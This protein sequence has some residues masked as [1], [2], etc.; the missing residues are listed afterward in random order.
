M[1]GHRVLVFE[2]MHC[3]PAN[4]YSTRISAA[5]RIDKRVNIYSSK[6]IWNLR[7]NRIMSLQLIYCNEGCSLYTLL[8]HDN[9]MQIHPCS[10]PCDWCKKMHDHMMQIGHSHWLHSWTG[11][12]LMSIQSFK[13]LGYTQCIMM[14]IQM[15]LHLT[16][17]DHQLFARQV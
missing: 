7:L 12:F 4:A 13:Y 3:E 2:L 14:F 11:C 15:I 16:W 9:K 5:M 8:W 17:I 6:T 10:S 1:S